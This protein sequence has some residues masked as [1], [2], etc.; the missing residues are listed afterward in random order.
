MHSTKTKYLI[1]TNIYGLSFRG[2]YAQIAKFLS[3]LKPDDYVVSCFVLAE[4]EAVRYSFFN[5]AFIE[6]IST[7]NQSQIVW[8]DRR[9]LQVFALLKYNMS[10]RKINNRTIDYFIASQCL[11]GDYTL[12]TANKKDFEQ[13]PNLKAKYFDQHNSRWFDANKG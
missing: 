12:V 1:D 6:L 13:I 4:L 7:L 8:F 3:P 10:Q 2:Q 9:Q 11:Y 5:T